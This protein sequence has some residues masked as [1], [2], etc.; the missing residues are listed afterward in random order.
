MPKALKVVLIIVALFIG[1]GI[2]LFEV[3]NLDDPERISPVLG[4]W[5]AITVVV[6]VILLSVRL[7]RRKSR[8]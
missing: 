5:I 2:L 8:G 1:T 3:L 7:A 4:G 6:G